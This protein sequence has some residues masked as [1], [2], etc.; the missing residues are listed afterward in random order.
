MTRK[1]LL[2]LVMLTAIS[3]LV[4]ACGGGDGGVTASSGAGTETALPDESGSSIDSGALPSEEEVLAFFEQAVATLNGGDVA[5]YVVL[6]SD[7]GLAQYT[8][9]TVTPAEELRPLTVEALAGGPTITVTSVQDIEPYERN[10]G[11]VVNT[12]QDDVAVSEYFELLPYEGSY[13]ID[14][15]EKISP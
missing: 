8:G 1:P 13:L 12:T 14:A 6:F 5:G 3:V 10:I 11:V 7:K 9:D 15:Y 2:F 4:A